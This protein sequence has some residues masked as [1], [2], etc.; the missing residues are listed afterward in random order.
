MSYSQIFQAVFHLLLS[1]VVYAIIYFRNTYACVLLHEREKTENYIRNNKGCVE[2]VL[3]EIG[4]PEMVVKPRIVFHFYT[5]I[6]F[7]K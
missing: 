3:D 7:R 6:A 1:N 5:L 2:N 4:Q